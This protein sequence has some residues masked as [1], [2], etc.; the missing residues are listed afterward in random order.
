M[1]RE[2][3]RLGVLPAGA[4]RVGGAGGAG[5]VAGPGQRPAR[6]ALELSLGGRWRLAAAVRPPAQRHGP[7]R[8]QATLVAPGPG[9]AGAVAV[10]GVV[11]RAAPATGP[12]LAA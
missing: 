3:H 8:V 10:R 4:S 9:A 12:D 11:G 7:R 2:A 5:A 6:A 1:G